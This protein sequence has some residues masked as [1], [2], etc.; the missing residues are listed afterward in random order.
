MVESF[1][2]LETEANAI[3][4]SIRRLSDESSTDLSLIDQL[5]DTYEAEAP[6]S[7][8]A[9]TDMYAAAGVQL[10]DLVRRR[11]AEVSLFHDS[12][13]QNRERHLSEEISLAEL[14]VSLREEEKRVLDSR[15]GDLLRV[16]STGGALAELTGLQEELAKEQTRLEE[17]RNSYRIADELA[18]GKAGV[19]RARQ[20]LYVELQEDQ[21]ER[22]GQLGRII[23]RFEEFSARLYDE[24]VGSLEIGASE[25]GPTFSIDID[26]GKSKGINNMQIF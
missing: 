24:R 4:T 26:A 13:V 9:V 6:P 23:Q 17:F 7:A 5:M 20:S 3:S 25:N 11:F 1:S 18:A 22:E 15:R 2:D 21:R 16:L 8:A 19:K 14:R 10:G 12:I